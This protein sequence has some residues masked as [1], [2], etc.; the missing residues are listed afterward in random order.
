[1][2]ALNLQRVQ[3]DNFSLLHA[4]FGDSKEFAK[5]TG[6]SYST[7]LAQAHCERA[8]MPASCRAVESA[9]GLPT[10][11]MDQERTQLDNYARNAVPNGDVR[12]RTNSPELSARRMANLA[13]LAGPMRGGRAELCR[14]AGRE[15]T[16]FPNP[17]TAVIG[18]RAAGRWETDLGLP[19]G[20]LDETHDLHLP[21]PEAFINRIG[22]IMQ[23]L[24]RAPKP[25]SM[26]SRP[27]AAETAWDRVHRQMQS[28]PPA[29]PVGPVADAPVPKTVPKDRQGI[30]DLSPVVRAL[31]EQVI[32]VSAKG[33]LSDAKALRVLGD[34]IALETE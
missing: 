28:A 18:A 29:T 1:M 5:A 4:A 26:A 22:R 14:K 9:L 8:L 32:A 15:S 3:N 6:L 23:L 24:A 16:Q 17:K 33:L 34:M 2:I 10:H 11:W 21:M 31:V 19:F 25:A 30:T 27:A 12:L 13:W 20:W 7:V